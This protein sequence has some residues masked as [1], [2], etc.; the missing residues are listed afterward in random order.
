[1]HDGA[2]GRTLRDLRHARGLTV[3]AL[4]RQIGSHRGYISMIEN[5][6][7]APPSVKKILRLAKVLDVD[8]NGLILMAYADKAPEM[9]R[10][11][12]HRAL[13]PLFPRHG[14]VPV[15]ESARQ[16]GHAGVDG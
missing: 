14:A 3:E 12:V 7:V 6:K 1:M 4:A 15:A 13:A 5:R 2:F 9:V 16:E 8:A 11:V 10:G